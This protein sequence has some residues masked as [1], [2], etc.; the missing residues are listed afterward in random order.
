MLRAK[1]FSASLTVS[2]GAIQEMF[3][4]M[5]TYSDWTVVRV[6]AMHPIAVRLEC[7]KILLPNMIWSVKIPSSNKIP[8]TKSDTL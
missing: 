2:K 5:K 3:K 1:K 4:F 8:T 7:R 6:T